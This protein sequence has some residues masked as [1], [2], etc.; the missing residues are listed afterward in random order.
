MTADLETICLKCLEREPGRRYLSAADL[1]ED[2][3][4]FL[5]GEPILARPISTLRRWV[6]WAP[7]R[8]P[9]EAALAAWL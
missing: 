9:A 8:R 3:R 4:R 6:K 2:L 5:T 7:R 1:A